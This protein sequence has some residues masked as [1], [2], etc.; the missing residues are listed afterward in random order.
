VSLG[1]TASRLL[2]AAAL[3]CAGAFAVHDL[4][5]VFEY[6]PGASDAL[7][8]QGHS[9]MPVVEASIAIFLAAACLLFLRVLFLAHRGSQIEPA[10]PQFARLW[11]GASATLLAIYTLQEGLEGQFSAGHP[12][13]LWGIFGHGGWTAVPLAL[14]IGALVALLLEGAHRAIVRV[15]S[16]AR[17]GRPRPAHAPGPAP[18]IV[19]P[20]LDPV[21]RN[22]A[23]RGPP[24]VSLKT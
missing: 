22:L 5:Y 3:V 1:W 13:G 23:A 15:G 17:A 11:A 24:P 6:G 16:R 4:R 20:R 9:Y 2:R 19:F 14:A 12:S 21:S 7:S 18:V 8:L 10:V